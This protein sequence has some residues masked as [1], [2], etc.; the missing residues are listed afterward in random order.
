MKQPRLIC[1]ASH[2]LL[3]AVTVVVALFAPSMSWAVNLAQSPLTTQLQLQPNIVLMFDDSGSMNW[4]AM[5]DTLSNT[6][7]NEGF[8]SGDINGVY[9]N[10]LITY[11][12]PYTETATPPTVTTRMANSAFASAPFD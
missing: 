10:P 9:Y 4:N 11:N 1:R 2:H 7:V 8:I 5:P 3:W 6:N 12:P